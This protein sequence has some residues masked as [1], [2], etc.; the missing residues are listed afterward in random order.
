M[1]DKGI[2]MCMIRYDSDIPKVIND[3]DMR[4]VKTTETGC[5]TGTLP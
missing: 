1:C 3:A 4:L 2:T 5:N